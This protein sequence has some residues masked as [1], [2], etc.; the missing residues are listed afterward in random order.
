MCPAANII[1]VHQEIRSLKLKYASVDNHLFFFRP[2]YAPYSTFLSL[3]PVTGKLYTQAE[4]RRIKMTFAKCLI[5]MTRCFAISRRPY[6]RLMTSGGWVG[7]KWSWRLTELHE[8]HVFITVQTSVW[9]PLL[10]KARCMAEGS[11]HNASVAVS[12]THLTLPTRRTV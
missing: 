4:K 5:C 8:M 6:W 9:W 7:E 3:K 10:L 12:Y 1:D 2:A 11:V